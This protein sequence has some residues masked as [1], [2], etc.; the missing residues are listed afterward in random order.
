MF[1]AYLGRSELLGELAD[2]ELR[3]VGQ[4]C[5]PSDARA[6]RVIA[7]MLHPRTH[8]E[9]QRRDFA[10]RLEVLRARD[11]VSVKFQHMTDDGYLRHTAF[12]RF[13]DEL[14][15]GA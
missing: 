13:T 8:F 2:G 6:I 4:V 9:V 1:G 12:K 14:N 3:Y 11:P 10:S 15:A 7:R 5:V